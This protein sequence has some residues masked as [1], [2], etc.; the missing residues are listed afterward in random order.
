M[1]YVFKVLKDNTHVIQ[2]IPI[3]NE[4]CLR[5]MDDIILKMN[6]SVY[7]SED[8]PDDAIIESW[9]CCKIKLYEVGFIL[10]ENNHDINMVSDDLNMSSF[11][12]DCNWEEDCL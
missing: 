5:I 9:E 12:I 2:D 3:K 10:S 11:L 7:F 6:E 1:N 8:A 4:N